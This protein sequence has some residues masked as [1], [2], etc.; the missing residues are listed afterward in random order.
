MNDKDVMGILIQQKNMRE[1]EEL[2]N[3]QKTNECLFNNVSSDSKDA[4]YTE[5]NRLA[6]EIAE[7]IKREKKE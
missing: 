3:K 2:E 6:K 5:S 1:T 4:I 7:A